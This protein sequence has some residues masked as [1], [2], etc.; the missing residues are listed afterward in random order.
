MKRFDLIETADGRWVR[1]R[2]ARDEIERLVDLL[3]EVTERACLVTG[4][5]PGLY[6]CGIGVYADA[7]RAL[8]A[9][10]RVDIASDI[11]CRVTARRRED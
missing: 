8:A 11:G 7:L 5:G 6:S 4:P 3:Q 9:R 10:G 1:T 2:D